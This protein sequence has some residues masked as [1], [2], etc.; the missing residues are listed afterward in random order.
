[1]HRWKHCTVTYFHLLSARLMFL[2]WFLRKYQKIVC[3]VVAAYIP[4]R[5][6]TK[7]SDSMSCSAG[8]AGSLTTTWNFQ[9]RRTW[10]MLEV[11]VNHG[12][13]RNWTQ[14][15][16][17]GFPPWAARSRQGRHSHNHSRHK[18]HAPWVRNV[19]RQEGPENDRAV[20]SKQF[21]MRALQSSVIKAISFTLVRKFPT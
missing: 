12:Q 10:R 3:F 2:W 1:M 14:S 8:S 17:S 16:G 21:G 9:L 7:A 11:T 19:W 13:Q 4:E 15:S 6:S 5:P 20:A 18:D